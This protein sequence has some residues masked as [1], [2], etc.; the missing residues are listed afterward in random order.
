MSIVFVLVGILL[1]F[2]GRSILAPDNYSFI[3]G[4]NSLSKEDQDRY[5]AVIARD[6][7]QILKGMGLIFIL[8]GGMS[9]LSLYILPNVSDYCL[10][11]LVSIVLLYSAYYLLKKREYPTMS[12]VVA[13]SLS[14]FLIVMAL[15]LP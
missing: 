11:L 7:N 1:V 3:S 4:F 12:R 6:T 15:A 10:I 5:G 13:I 8:G 2:L 9:F 14:G